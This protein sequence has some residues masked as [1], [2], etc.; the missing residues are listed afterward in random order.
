[1]LCAIPSYPSV[2][3]ITDGHVSVLPE[4][5]GKAMTRKKSSFWNPKTDAWV[6]VVSSAQVHKQKITLWT[7][8]LFTL[9]ILNM[10][11]P[12]NINLIFAS[13]QM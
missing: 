2:S 9:V 10:N 5:P 8:K 1:M 4:C 12:D 13:I 6:G 7:D 11:C 3:T